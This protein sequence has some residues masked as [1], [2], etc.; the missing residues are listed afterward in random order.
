MSRDHRKLRVFNLAD[1]LVTAVYRA[2]VDFPIEE[3]YGLQQQLRRAAVSVPCNIVEGA[4]RSGQ[5][6]Y[7][8]FLNVAAGSASEARYLCDLSSRLGYLTNATALEFED[9]YREL[10]ASLQALMTSLRASEARS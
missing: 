10:R 7:L 4:A 8:A 6:E 1:N 5:K 2:S 3:R 9:S